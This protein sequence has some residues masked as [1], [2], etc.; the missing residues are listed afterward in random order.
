MKLEEQKNFDYTIG[1]RRL[2]NI[3]DEIRVLDMLIE[4][5]ER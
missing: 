4:F 5:L 1:G 2:N 3:N